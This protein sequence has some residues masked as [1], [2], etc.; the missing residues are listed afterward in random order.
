MGMPTSTALAP[1]RLAEL[2]LPDAGSVTR[3]EMHARETFQ[4][5]EPEQE[6]A[7][8]I[9]APTLLEDS[10]RILE[11]LRVLAALAEVAASLD[12]KTFA[13]FHA[14]VDEVFQAVRLSLRI[15][16]LAPFVADP[17]FQELLRR[18]QE[19]PEP[20]SH[21]PIRPTAS[22]IRAISSLVEFCPIDELVKIGEAA[23][24]AD[25]AHRCRISHD[26][27][28]AFVRRHTAQGRDTLHII[29][30]AYS[31]GRLNLDETA[32]LL[33]MPRPD[34]VAW[35]EENGHTRD[36]SVFS[37]SNDARVERLVRIRAERLAR[38][39]RPD[40]DLELLRRE[41]LAT[42]RIEGIDARPWVPYPS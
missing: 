34:V 33:G 22:V 32:N 2:G 1:E 18:R 21:F 20:P 12:I 10:V 4:R 3:I 39:G 13:D 25:L 31:Q 24:A 9:D 36:V 28:R 5:V 27:L 23:D 40:F 35:L 30:R 19:S 8:P 26:W 29:G 16:P 11:Q 41:V 7:V 17:A 15:D 6:E 42:Q 14:R 37:L 38:G